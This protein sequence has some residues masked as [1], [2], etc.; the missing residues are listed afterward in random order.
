MIWHPRPGQRIELRY[1]PAMRGVCPH[2][3]RG[4][5]EIVASGRI[6]NCQV[7]LDDGRR[8]IVPR[9]NLRDESKATVSVGG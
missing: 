4:T 6:V 1:R 5:V 9:G 7:W 2:G 3:Q 8:V